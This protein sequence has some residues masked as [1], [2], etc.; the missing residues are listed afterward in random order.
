M[1]QKIGIGKIQVGRVLAGILFACQAYA[2]TPSLTVAQSSEPSAQVLTT[3]MLWRIAPEERNPHLVR[4]AV[5][6]RLGLKGLRAV[7]HSEQ[8]PLIEKTFSIQLDSLLGK[9]VSYQRSPGQP[10]FRTLKD[11]PCFKREP[12]EIEGTFATE[13]G[14]H[15]SIRRAIELWENLVDDRRERL[16]Q[17]LATIRGRSEVQALQIADFMFLEWNQD[18]HDRWHREIVPR[19]RAEEW[20]AY[21]K[22]AAKSGKC[23]KSSAFNPSSLSWSTLLAPPDEDIQKSL[24]MRAPAKLWKN[25]ISVHVTLHLFDQR[26]NGTFLVDPTSPVS[27]VHPDFLERQGIETDWLITRGASPQAIVF[28]GE[29]RVAQPIIVSKTEMSGVE[30]D[31]WQYWLM[32]TE[33]YTP[34]QYRSSCCDGLIGMDVL[35]KYAVEIDPRKPAHVTFWDRSRFSLGSKIRWKPIRWDTPFDWRQWPWT[36]KASVLDLSNGRWWFLQGPEIPQ[37][38]VNRSGLDL[39]YVEVEKER[40][41]HVARIAPGSAAAG[42]KRAGLKPGLEIT[43][44]NGEKTGE[45]DQWQVDE[46]LAGKRTQTLTLEWAS[47][48]GPRIVPLALPL[49]SLSTRAKSE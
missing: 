3:E 19:V 4:W 29:S 17:K 31:H 48:A 10:W 2:A 5:D 37:P 7:P 9:T 22:E 11:F 30:V 39:Q 38:W 23:Q 49:P 44:L 40:H 21:A 16:A 34:P 24:V 41:L 42:L 18:L 27:L 28:R 43:Q 14:T 45:L 15:R 36:E 1:G 32:D 33:M 46:M 26:L 13:E 8:D 35:R 12:K 6:R 20:T 47:P 25:G